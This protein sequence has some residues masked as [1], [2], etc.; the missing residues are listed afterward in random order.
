MDSLHARAAIPKYIAGFE[1]FRT[2]PDH[3]AALCASKDVQFSRQT[4]QGRIKIQNE[5]TDLDAWVIQLADGIWFASIEQYFS[6]AEEVKSSG[7]SSPV[8]FDIDYIFFRGHKVERKDCQLN[9]TVTLTSSATEKV[10]RVAADTQLRVY[11]FI[12][13]EEFQSE[14]LGHGYDVMNSAIDATFNRS[15]GRYS[16][17]VAPAEIYL[18]QQFER[19]IAVEQLHLSDITQAR[20]ILFRLWTTFFDTKIG[21]ASSNNLQGMFAAAIQLLNDNIENS[22][23]GLQALA[24]ACN[25]SVP[26]FKRKFKTLFFTTPE[27]Y[28]RCLQMEKAETLMK[29]PGTTVR[30]LA[31]RFGYTSQQSFSSTYNKIKGYF[32]S[33]LKR[34]FGDIN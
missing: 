32:P 22:F 12:F 5:F 29:M 15:S 16:R 6:V 20:A 17:R 14:N 10:T 33:T 18:L 4:G 34:T 26:T 8:F 9:N 7:K 3:L 13:T 24:S 11:K 28:F 19:T 2:H 27:N 21:Y 31:L 1:Y 23:P 30:E 25:V